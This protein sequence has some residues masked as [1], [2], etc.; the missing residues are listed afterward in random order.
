MDRRLLVALLLIPIVLYWYQGEIAA[1]LWSLFHGQDTS[2]ALRWAIWDSTMYMVKEYP[3]FGIGWNTYWLEYP[4]YNYF[5]QSTHVL[6]Y[7]AHNLYLNILA[8]T[9]FLGLF[10]FLTILIGHAVKATR[11]KGDR[12][13]QAAQYGV[14]ALVIAVLV[15]GVTD[16]ELYSHQ[17]SVVFWQLLGLIGA[18]MKLSK[19]QENKEN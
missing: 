16:F 19:E 1:R 2:V 13:R 11:L 15:S 5:I 17:V 14:G 18:F 7:H 6:M 8:E 10:F 3:V 12:L 9:G 4:E